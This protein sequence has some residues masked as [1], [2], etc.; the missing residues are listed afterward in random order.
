M[1]FNNIPKP[2]RTKAS[3]TPLTEEQLAAWKAEF[4]R[5]LRAQAQL[6]QPT[7]QPKPQAAQPMRQTPPQTLQPRQLSFPPVQ[8]YYEI[9]KM[10]R[11]PLFPTE[12]PQPE[13]PPLAQMPMAETPVVGEKR[14]REEAQQPTKAS[15]EEEGYEYSYS[16]GSLLGE[17]E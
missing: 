10:K 3:L 12:R 8:L 9:P 16:S 15:A 17:E 7:T 5:T 13:Q 4:E 6:Q 14:D 1:S 11:T 2:P